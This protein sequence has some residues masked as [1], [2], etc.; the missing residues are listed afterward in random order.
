MVRFRLLPS[1]DKFFDLFNAAATNVAE[2][3]RRLG[4][5]VGQPGPGGA[6]TIDAVIACERRGDDLTRDILR[7]LNT[8]FVTPFDREDIHA[9]AE[10]LDDVVDDVL[11]VALRLDLGDRDVGAMP[12]LKEQAD[13]LVAMAD[14]VAK[15]VAGLRSMDGLQPLLD[16]VDRL[17]SEG[18]AIYR[19]A[20]R[21]LYSVEFKPRATLYWKDVVE[22]ME[23]ALDTMEDI[24]DV[25]EAIA[26]K[27]A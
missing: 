2:C 3:S 23:H 25:V 20:L 21:R 22:T 6:A 7:R 19:Q 17:E 24:S 4:E 5:L 12:E 10:E 1:D 26:L 16:E 14:A 27:H 11:E 8:S 18:D 13:V 15:L 9:L